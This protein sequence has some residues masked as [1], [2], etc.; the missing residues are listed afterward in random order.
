MQP[1][2]EFSLRPATPEDNKFLY[3][4]YASTR[5]EELDL[6]G[7]PHSEREAFCRM[8]FGLRQ[9][10]Y[11]L[12]YASAADRILLWNGDRIGR[13][14]IDR[15]AQWIELIDIAIL[16]THQ[17]RG[18]GSA[19]LQAL[20]KESVECQLPIHLFADQGSRAQALY[21]RHGFVIAEDHAPHWFMKRAASAP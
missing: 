6:A 1:H 7:F 9:H 19:L 3:Q 16:P 5:A 10:H 11:G 2:P 17:G 8:Q 12:H 18:I 13:E 4:L 20:I 15:Q 21:Q 14:L